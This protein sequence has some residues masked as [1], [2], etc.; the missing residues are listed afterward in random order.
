MNVPAGTVAVGKSLPLLEWAT[1][2]PA[3]AVR[4]DPGD[5][6]AAMWSKPRMLGAAQAAPPTATPV[7]VALCRNSRRWTSDIASSLEGNR[8][9]RDCSAR[10]AS[11]NDYRTGAAGR[12]TLAPRNV[13]VHTTRRRSLEVAAATSPTPTVVTGRIGR[14]IGRRSGEASP[15]AVVAAP[16]PCLGCHDKLGR[17]MP[18][19]PIPGRTATSTDVVIPLPD[20]F[21][22]AIDGHLV[23]LDVRGGRGLLLNGS[24]ALILTA[25]D[26][27]RT[28]AEI[29][30]AARRRDGNGRGP[31]HG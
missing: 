31:D 29:V 9:E 21:M 28:V 4:G 23:V 20:A 30:D 25:F 26:G 16:P 18:V 3:T 17:P 7:M 27:E 5:T 11:S 1:A 22:A 10:C 19:E 15:A 24:A 14:A 6:A 13:V 2:V 8:V 12:R